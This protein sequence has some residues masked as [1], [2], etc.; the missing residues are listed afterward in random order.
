MPVTTETPKKFKRG[1]LY[2]ETGFEYG[3]SAQAALDAG[4]EDVISIEMSTLYVLDGKKRFHGRPV[5]IHLSDSVNGL[6]RV[7]PTVLEPATIYL[8]AHPNTS[9][10]ILDELAVIKEYGI[11]DHTILVDDRRLMHG[12][13]NNVV[14]EQVHAALLAINPSY[15]ILLVEG[16]VPEDII[17]ARADLR[18]SPE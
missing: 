7:L 11:K 8:D 18:A 15:E 9:S 6:R 2:L 13:W 14:E 3:H 5:I 4:F 17:V 16:H 12:I 10:P 1:S